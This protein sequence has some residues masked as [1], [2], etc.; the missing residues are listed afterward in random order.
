MNYRRTFLA[1]LV[2]ACFSSACT[3]SHK[4][5]KP[6]PKNELLFTGSETCKSCHEDIY[7]KHQL[8]PH[9][10]TSQLAD[11]VSIK[12]S[13]E[14]G[15]N[16]FF[17]NPELFVT[18]DKE[19][20]KFVQTL[21]A[22]NKKIK[23][24][25]FDLVFGSGVRGQTYLSW[26]DST[27]FQLPI[28]Y[29]ASV[30]SWANSPGF[31]NRP[32][33][34][35]PITARCLECHSTYFKKI[36]SEKKQPEHFSKKQFYLGVDCEKCHGPGKQHVNFHQQNTQTKEGKFITSF[37]NFTRTQQLD[38]CRSC[39]G[40]KLIASKPA[41]SFKAGENLNDYFTPDSVQ[42][43]GKQLD[44]HGNQ[45]G[46]LSQSKCFLQS[47]MTCITCH[48]VHENEKGMVATFSNR[49][50]SCHREG[51][52]S[53]CTTKKLSVSM[54]KQN[55]IQCHMPEKNSNSIRMLLQGDDVPTPAKMHVHQ[56]T[57]YQDEVVKYINSMPLT[58][59]R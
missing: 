45:F 9:H 41:F 14:E 33:F 20:G 53:F 11:S 52:K 55:C 49:C 34:N 23:T 58:K 56:I 40:G 1:I 37:K 26:Q 12:G 32:I 27:L 17:Y 8:T 46:M 25:S 18:M 28:G 42:V 5:E 51:T 39:H 50:M 15:K 29:L 6:E 35:R 43:P 24:R 47:D 36:V 30:D 10:L 16:L 7:K 54:L 3:T 59:T 48:N 19:H 22:R 21:Y 44:S 4:T 2:Y 13:F 38:F 57:V 31:S